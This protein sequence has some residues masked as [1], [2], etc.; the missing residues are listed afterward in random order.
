MKV[1]FTTTVPSPYRVDFFNE[2]GKYC[3]LTVVFER[4]KFVDRDKSWENFKFENFQGIFLSKSGMSTI[5]A[6]SQSAI[7]LIKK[8]SFDKI[9]VT[10]FSTPI[11]ILIVNFLKRTKTPYFLESD[12]AFAKKS[13]GLKEIFKKRIISGAE[14][15]FSTAKE[16]DEYYKSYGVSADK[17]IRYHFSSVCNC[18]VVSEPTSDKL[19]KELRDKLGIKED[20]VVLAIGQFI[21]RKGFDTLIRAA[22]NLSSD[23]GFYFVGGE[24]TEEYLSLKDE[25]KLDNVHF[26]GFKGKPELKE[27]YMSADVFVHPTRLDIWGLVINEAM[28]YGLPVITTTKCI[29]GLEMLSDKRMIV[30]PEMSNSLSDVINQLLNDDDL[31]NRISKE[32]LKTAA[33][34]TIETMCADHV[35]LFNL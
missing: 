23:I 9:V 2:L 26:V 18:D 11:G 32:N 34:Y 14:G 35:R 12:G 3:D 17:M 10:N 28:A 1:L 24:P 25:L 7:K 8:Q 31:R 21:Y 15:Y 20:K 27:Y 5:F 30:E 19:K 29:A 16:H 22:V 13:K 4:N 6:D 33:E